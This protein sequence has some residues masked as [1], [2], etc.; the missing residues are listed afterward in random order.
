MKPLSDLQVG[1]RVI[2][3]KESATGYRRE[4]PARV[5]GI[6]DAGVSFTIIEAQ[7]FTIPWGDADRYIAEPRSMQ[8]YGP[9]VDDGPLEG[10]IPE[11]E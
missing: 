4:L 10:T 2:Y 11:L 7:D 6:T 5:T 9:V 3:V 1:D 8:A